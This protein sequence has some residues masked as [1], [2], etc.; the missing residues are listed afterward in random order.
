MRARTKSPRYQR[1]VLLLSA[2]SGL[3]AMVVLSLLPIGI[4]QGYSFARDS[5]LLYAEPIQTLKWMR[6]IGDVIF[7]VGIFYFCWFTIDETI[8]NFKRKEV[9]K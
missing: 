9:N 6:M 3:V 7:S 8:Y 4:I 2:P 5:D 1:F